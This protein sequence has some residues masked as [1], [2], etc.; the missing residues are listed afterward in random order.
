[1]PSPPFVRRALAVAAHDGRV[2]AIG[3]MRDEGGPTRKVDVYDPG[4]SQWSHGPDI[5]GDDEIA[6][7][8]PS[9]FAAGGNLYVS[10]IK[11]TLQ[12]L[13]ENGSSWEIVGQLP[14]S[15]FFHRMLPLDGSRLLVVGGASM[16]SG[17]FDTVEALQ[18]G[19]F[20]SSAR[21]IVP[22][23]QDGIGASQLQHDL[24]RRMPL[25]ASDR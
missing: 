23:V 21:E 22:D 14:T 12:R 3:G 24:F 17:K 13:S 9:A 5:Q 20:L 10:T 6:G 19:D 4:T 11:G 16:E 7:F 15:R 25:S 1:M 2:Y 18:L 8:G